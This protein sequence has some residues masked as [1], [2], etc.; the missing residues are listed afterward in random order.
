MFC[1]LGRWGSSYPIYTPLLTLTTWVTSFP[2]KIFHWNSIQYL[3]VTVNKVLMRV[4][5]LDLI[6]SG[7]TY[8]SQPPPNEHMIIIMLCDLGLWDNVLD[9]RSVEEGL[10]NKLVHFCQYWIL[11]MMTSFSPPPPLSTPF[12]R[13]S[14]TK[15]PSGIVKWRRNPVTWSKTL[16]FSFLPSLSLVFFLSFLFLSFELTQWIEWSFE[17]IWFNFFYHDYFLL[18]FSITWG[19]Y[20]NEILFWIDNF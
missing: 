12:F 7:R 18:P 2:L 9:G 15:D 16:L 5:F 13:P 10:N 8:R 20:N 17:F 4:Y 11:V 3:K 19:K 6:Q 1:L 14:P